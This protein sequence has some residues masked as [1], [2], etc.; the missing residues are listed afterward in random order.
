VT[1]ALLAAITL[2]P[3]PTPTPAVIVSLDVIAL[4]II[5]LGGIVPE[6]IVPDI[7]ASL[8]PIKRTAFKLAK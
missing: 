2:I 7:E 8:A 3:A 1:P 4:Y 6:V 5:A